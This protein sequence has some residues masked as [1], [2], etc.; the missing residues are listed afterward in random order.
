ML[1]P[2]S[3]LL[4]PETNRVL[5]IRLQQ[6]PVDKLMRKAN[7]MQGPG[8]RRYDADFESKRLGYTKPERNIGVMRSLFHTQTLKT[9]HV[10]ETETKKIEKE[11]EILSKIPSGGFRSNTDGWRGRKMC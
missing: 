1:G 11:V 6:I 3:R 2:G 9:I 8:D 10:L 4:L 7:C 5:F